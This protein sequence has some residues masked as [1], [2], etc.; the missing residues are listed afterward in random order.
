MKT[1]KQSKKKTR[2]TKR[3]KPFS[4]SDMS[5]DDAMKLIVK[6]KPPKKK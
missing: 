4:L 2:K 5:F 3:E 6:A 1:T